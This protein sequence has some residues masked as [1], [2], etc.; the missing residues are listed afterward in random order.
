MTATYLVIQ[1]PPKK[2]IIVINSVGIIDICSKSELIN[3]IKNPN[4]AKVNA[5]K[6]SKKIIKN[7]C[8]T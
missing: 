2:T 5:T 1:I 4:K 8:L 3:P 6:I 7:G